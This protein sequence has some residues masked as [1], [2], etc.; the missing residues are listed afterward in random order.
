MKRI[1]NKD[2]VFKLSLL[3]LA[4]VAVAGCSSNDSSSQ[5]LNP[6][7]GTDGGGSGSDGG[8]Q[9]FTYGT[10]NSIDD[11]AVGEAFVLDTTTIKATRRTDGSEGATI[12]A[13]PTV[14]TNASITVLEDTA[15]GNTR[16]R[17]RDPE[18]GVDIELFGYSNEPFRYTN[19]D[20]DELEL[21]S[22]DQPV[23][24]LIP[25]GGL[26]YAA[27]GFWSVPDGA[28]DVDVGFFAAGYATQ[29]GDMPTIGTASFSGVANGFSLTSDGNA[30]DVIGNASMNVDFAAG[31]LTGAM[32]NMRSGERISD[33]F[34]SN[35]PWNDIGF[36]GMLTGNAFSADAN[37]TSSP[38]NA[39]ALGA[40]AA[41][42]ING[43]FYGPQA[44]EA[45]GTWRFR[46]SSGG[47]A[48]G[49]FGVKKD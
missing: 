15:D 41:G 26:S 43:R 30:A 19:G 45:A 48:F 33:A 42:N 22:Q 27:Y 39:A 35:T 2:S 3:V 44:A 18:N 14:G 24:S 20:G 17:L 12:N 40:D 10:I 29:S 47:T 11:I 49:G 32:T 16:L 23:S 6:G 28:N 9:D 7:G 1:D 4:I 21:Y 38:D 8:G 37:A 25:S 34:N 5:A 46:D 13:G 31:T 36:S